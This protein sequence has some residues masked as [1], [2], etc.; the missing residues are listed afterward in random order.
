MNEDYKFD[1]RREYGT[2]QNPSHMP[3]LASQFNIIPSRYTV[4]S[5][6]QESY[7]LNLL[8]IQHNFYGEN[9]KFFELKDLI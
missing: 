4:S 2:Y 8:N 6:P 7:V 9:D 1:N 3:Q 5:I